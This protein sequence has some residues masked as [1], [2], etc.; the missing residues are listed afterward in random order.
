M[1]PHFRK[2][3]AGKENFVRQLLARAIQR[4]HGDEESKIKSG[5]DHM[6][7]REGKA[8][9]KTGRNPKYGEQVMVNEVGTQCFLSLVTFDP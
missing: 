2:Y 6:G 5:L 7:W 1:S 4:T 3:F 8:A 9:T